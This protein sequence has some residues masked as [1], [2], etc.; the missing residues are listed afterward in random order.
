MRTKI[1]I[2]GAGFVGS[3]LAQR[4]AERDYADVVMYDIVPNMPQGKALDMLQAG[5]VLGYDSL[6]VGTNDYAD[7][8][9]SDLVVITSGFPRKPGMSR[10]DLLRKNQEIVTQVVQEIIKYSPNC[11]LIVVTNPLDAM[12]QLAYHVSGFPR[13]RVV[14][15][16]GVL[17]TARF[18]TFIA[19]ELNVSVRDVQAYVLGGHGDTMV[20][21]AR[22][23]TVA[24]VPISQ[25]LPAE[26]IEQIIQRTRDGGAEIVNLLGTGSAY[27][28]P[29]AAVL[30][31]IDSIVLD[32]KMIMPCSAYLQG[33]YGIQNLFVGVPVKLGANGVEQ[34]IEL[35]LTEDERALLQKSA[36]AV[37]ELV[38]VMGI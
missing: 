17:D 11:M 28:A 27:F 31:M 24:G 25:L 38:K 13:N 26:R 12:A 35:E 18:R 37:Q 29:S 9:N 16:A 10:D 4:L 2:V 33:E 23:C 20:P 1:T 36:A 15:M 6:I 21:L 7:T 14:G 3:T 19:Q 22:M 30:Q 8:A 34:I 5:P 32:K